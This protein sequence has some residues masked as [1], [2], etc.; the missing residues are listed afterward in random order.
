MSRKKTILNV[1]LILFIL[2]FFVTPLGH[3]GKILLNRLFSFSP[4]AIAQTDRVQIA[5]YDWKLKD[6]D[7]NFF[8]FERSKGRVVLINFWASWRL[9]CEAELAS[10]QA[11]YD[12][13]QGQLDF[14][15]ITNEDRPPVEAFMKKHGFTF[16]L[17]YLIIGDKAPFSIPKPPYSFLLNKEGY[18]V[19]EQEGI[20]DWNTK[21]VFDLIDSLL[22]E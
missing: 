17:T 1:L 10:I 13:Y 14:Y 4:T 2:S 5:D 6:A 8:S 21:A 3:Y 12:R 16:P 15:L 18:I 20:A 7:W 19:V 11:L 9:P 22:A